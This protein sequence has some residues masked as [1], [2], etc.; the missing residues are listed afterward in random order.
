MFLLSK[1]LV[2]VNV[3]SENLRRLDSPVQIFN[4]NV[5]LGSC[6]VEEYLIVRRTALSPDLGVD[7]QDVSSL[8]ILQEISTQ[9][10]ILWSRQ[11]QQS[12][13]LDDFS[14]LLG[15]QTMDLAT[16]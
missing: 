7:I 12:R 14:A 2:F 6:T 16:W 1:L 15:R 11:S 10:S 4:R 13:H 3:E 9:N 8:V 5:S